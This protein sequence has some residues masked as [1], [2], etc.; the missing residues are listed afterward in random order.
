[1]AKFNRIYCANWFGQED[2][3]LLPLQDNLFITNYGQR[4]IFNKNNYCN[5][6]EIHIN[7]N[8]KAKCTGNLMTINR[9]FLSKSPVILIFCNSK[10][11]TIKSSHANYQ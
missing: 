1:M 11:C 2:S 10:K 5:E 8:Y 4:I 7:L 6:A 9:D 3:I